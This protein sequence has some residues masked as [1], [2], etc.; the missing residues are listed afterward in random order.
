M[1]RLRSRRFPL[2]VVGLMVIVGLIVAS[3]G[4]DPTP[5]P[6][7][8]AT[9]VPPTATAVPEATAMPEPTDT[10][11]PPTATPAPT[12]TPAPPEPDRTVSIVTAISGDTQSQD[13][14]QCL[15]NA[16]SITLVQITDPLI[17][18]VPAGGD[19]QAAM[20]TE[21]TI[22]SGGDSIT[23]KL[24]DA[25]FHDGTPFNA[26]AVKFNID[27]QIDPENEF[28]QYGNF[29]YR[30]TFLSWVASAD[31]VDDHTVRLNMK[32]PTASALD[33]S[34]TNATATLSPKA[35]SEL[36]GDIIEHPISTG[37]YKL[38][39]WDKG[40][41][42]V[43]ERNDDYWG[44]AP[45]VAESIY[46][47]I[48]DDTARL[49]ALRN[50][51]AQ[52][53]VDP[54]LEELTALDADA[55]FTVN[56]KTIR[57]L[58]FVSFN[59]NAGPLGSPLVRQAIN[60]AID[61]E[62]IA[63]DLLQGVAA[64]AKGLLS[65][66][67][68]QWVNQDIAGHPYN[69]D[70]ARELLAEAGYPDGFQTTLSFAAVAP[71]LPKATEVATVIQASL[72]EIGIEVTLDTREF[73]EFIGALFGGQIEEMALTSILASIADPDNWY[74]NLFATSR[75]SPNGFNFSY[76]GNSDLDALLD[77]GRT[78]FDPAERKGIYDQAQEVTQEDPPYGSIVYLPRIIA[79]TSDITGLE[80][81][82]NSVHFV[83][84][85][86]VN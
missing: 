5:T 61:K 76:Y 8:T 34:S 14:H 70:K 56:A 35:I 74:T 60:Y 73:S 33:F 86:T 66:G 15:D 24:R 50:G 11:V 46:I 55:A 51:T 26:E 57:L 9:S 28:H 78:T 21:W 84:D 18:E 52:M 40:V 19:V 39:E 16:C 17:N 41:R 31:V 80:Q 10:P 59:L 72:A 2:A 44:D 37:P 48:P 64:P 43:L 67:F 23:F 65:P 81:Y 79:H 75:Q 6:A 42:R 82:A 29:T 30:N 85:I 45:Q 77:R 47:S 36:Q 69:L 53:I 49:A 71:N 3:C 20:A 25:N 32:Q 13:P 38:A 58:Y 12:P 68:G 63:N 1:L 4:A 54:P 27:R 83:K 7:P 22:G 62:T